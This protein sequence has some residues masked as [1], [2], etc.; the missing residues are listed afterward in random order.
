MDGTARR[1][2]P[3]TGVAVSTL[4]IGGGSLANAAGAEGVRAVVD[5]AW[6]AGLRHFDTAALYAAGDSERRLGAALA[7]RKRDEFVVSTKVGRFIAAD[8]QE[9]FD[10]GASG[11]VAAVEIALGRL[12]LDRLDI[13]FVHD[14]IPDLH[15][16]AFERRF[17]EAVEG[18]L[19]ALAA[20]KRQGVVRAVGV[21]LRDPDVLLRF[22]RSAPCDVF[23]L[24]GGYSLLDQRAEAAFLPHCAR[25]GVPVLLAAPFE[26][27]LLATGAVPGARYRYRPA[28]PALLERVAAMEAACA[29]QG[30]PLAAAALQFPLR[31]A[32]IASVV[33]GHQAPP[34]VARNLD[35]LSL[36]IPEA[37]WAALGVG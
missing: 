7:G 17:A 2:I 1:A 11:T 35:L 34:E 9:A 36:P 10:Y 6:A 32:A 5:A 33:V 8:G 28:P 29:A 14:L 26:T 31:H 23:M 30:L 21:A 25:A 27:G 37:L 22:C 24:A 20:L 4:G 13:V 15:G 16:E 19:P 12:G 18:A 3:G